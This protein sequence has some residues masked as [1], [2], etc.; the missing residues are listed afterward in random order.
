ML[1]QWTTLLR[2]RRFIKANHVSVIRGSEPFVTGLYSY[3]LSRL[4]GLPFALRIGSNF[5]LLYKNGMMNFKKIYRWYFVEK[6]IARFVFS[7]CDLVCAATQNYLDYAIANGCPRE[8]AA[9]IRFGNIIDPVHL[10]DPRRR[11]PVP[12]RYDFMHNPF[13]VY[14]GRLIKIK[15]ADHLLYVAAEVKKTYPSIVIAMVGD[16]DIAESMK[17]EIANLGIEN[18][19][20]FLGKQK[21]D[22][23]ASLLPHASAYLAPHSGRSLV[24]AAYAGIPL[25]AYDWEWQAE[26]VRHQITGE[27][28]PFKDWHAMA[29]SFCRILS[30]GS[31]AR[32]LGENARTAVME[33][34]DP[35]KIQEIER[36][37]YLK[38][39]NDGK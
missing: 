7:R 13:G 38:I 39:L 24:E 29:N 9:L 36:A 35:E 12:H 27:L 33:M 26:L 28:V 18:N 3:L 11:P 16:G 30:D 34:M 10:A 21:Q 15:Q 14:V 8:K 25:I 31:Y 4:T 6:I 22:F 37:Q 2:A 23:V 5:D 19:V 20:V 32:K 17:D 1:S